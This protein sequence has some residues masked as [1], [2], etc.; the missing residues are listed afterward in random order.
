[1]D[2]RGHGRHKHDTRW[3]EAWF[4]WAW[5]HG[6][7]GHVRHE[8]HA[9]HGWLTWMDGPCTTTY[10]HAWMD[11]TW[12]HAG[13]PACGTSIGGHLYWWTPLQSDTFTWPEGPPSQ[14]VNVEAG[15]VEALGKARSRG[16][17]P[18]KWNI[19]ITTMC[20]H[21]VGIEVGGRVPPK[22]L[23]QRPTKSLQNQGSQEAQK[24]HS[25]ACRATEEEPCVVSRNAMSETKPVERPT[26]RVGGMT[27]RMNGCEDGC[28][29]AVQLPSTRCP[30][31]T[32]TDTLCTE[33]FRKI[34]ILKP[35]I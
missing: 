16:M 17:P 15:M 12:Q 21:F 3:M 32:P 13:E 24:E 30:A 8:Q 1:M 9:W 14:R 7:M 26:T 2:E 22:S 4:A 34:L 10:N 35:W 28:M 18:Q 11:G 20:S 29:G 25:G 31:G 23:A 19:S 5:M 33:A 27:K 6:V